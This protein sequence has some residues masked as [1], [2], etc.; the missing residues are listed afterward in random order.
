M[1]TDYLKLYNIKIPKATNRFRVIWW[2]MHVTYCYITKVTNNIKLMYKGTLANA[3]KEK[4]R[5]ISKHTF[6]INDLSN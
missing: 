5:V 4:G 3:I 1:I 6:V 2:Y